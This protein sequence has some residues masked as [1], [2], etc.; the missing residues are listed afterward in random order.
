MHCPKANKQHA[1]EAIMPIQTYD[2]IAHHA[3]TRGEAIAMEDLATG[4]TFTYAQFD[5]RVARLASGLQERFGIAR[6]D[7]VAVLAHNSTDMFELQFACSRIGAIFAPMNW[8]LTLPELRF[9]V[10][11]CQPLLLFYDPDFGDTALQ[12]SAACGVRHLCG[13][14]PSDSAYER[15]MAESSGDVTSAPVTHDDIATILYTSGTTGHPKGAIITHGMRFWQL[16]NLTGPCRV[17]TDSTCLVTLPQF[18]VGGLDVFANPVFHYGG[19]SVVMRAYDPAMTLRLFCDRQANITHFI[20]APAHYQFM[21]QLPQFAEARFNPN[22]LAYVAA[23]P[24]PLPLLHQWRDRGL[25]LIQG[26][27]MT[28]TCGVITMMEPA[29]ALPKAGSAGKPCLHLA[30]RLVGA[31]GTDAPA[32]EIG[33][34]WVKGPSNTPGYW[35]RPDATEATFTDGWLRTGDAALMDKDGFYYIVDRWKDM[36]ISGGENVYPAEVEDVLYQLPAIAEV[37]IIGV[38]DERWGEVG[39]AIIALKPHAVLTEAEIYQH[40][41]ANLAH[42]KHPRS[43]RFVEALPR[44]ATGKVHKPTLRQQFGMA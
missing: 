24:V 39:R 12:L 34:I 14:E 40:C 30:M 20:G 10:G 41:E 5:K 17:T 7:R 18:H 42:Y 29:D 32:G 23:A 22:L 2:W 31:D 3:S 8:R 15:L 28:E 6:G 26:Y 43:I 16:I 25:E 19:K 37:A 11:D 36:Y 38:M 35:Q 21:A 4:R 33:E 1:G 44:N 9:I 27:G 13:R